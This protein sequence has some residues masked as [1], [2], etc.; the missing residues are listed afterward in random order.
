MMNGA[1]FKQ[2]KYPSIMPEFLYKVCL[3]T[4]QYGKLGRYFRTKLCEMDKKIDKFKFPS[5]YSMG[6]K[7]ISPIETSINKPMEN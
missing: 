5:F 4:A 1:V 3:V 6:E 7:Q 2:L